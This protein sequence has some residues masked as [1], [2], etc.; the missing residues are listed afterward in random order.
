VV[1]KLIML[2]GIPKETKDH[3]YRIGVTPAGVK[4]LTNAGHQVRVETGAAE[5]IGYSDTA[6]RAAGAEIVAGP[7]QVYA[8]EL[9]IKVKE[10]QLS[11]LPL[12][13]A[14]QTLFCYLHLA[15]NAELTRALLERQIV[16]IAYETVT[17]AQGGTPL[18]M[19]MS[20]VAG[21]LSIQA[22]ARCLEMAGGGNGTLLSGVPGVLPAKVLILGG[23]AVGSNAARM[24]IGLGADVTLLDISHARLRHLEEVFGARL[25]TCYSD[26]HALEELIPAT[27]LVIGAIYLP[28]KRAAKLISRAHIASMQPGSALVDVAI[29]QGGCAETSRPTSH[30]HPTYIEEGVVHY[31]V[32][33]MPAACA[34]TSTQALTQVTL[35]YALRL[36]NQG[37][38]QALS[39][40][41]HLRNGLNVCLGKV[42]Y[43]A[44]ATD[45]G[46]DL[47]PAEQVVT[48]AS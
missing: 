22:G 21:R 7:A 26:A 6:Y 1:K 25:K 41:I 27:A 2:I 12:L 38:R 32:T 31:C 45:L 47:A 23:G 9:I 10:P 42:T 8:A 11:E 33:N 30:S 44:I 43:P 4:T 34:R 20:E 3:E 28:G 36:A 35:P 37:W 29:D 15:A 39:D 46:Y 14:G 24:A 17:D 19:P 5:K 48:V 18:L 16:G 40:D 13:Q